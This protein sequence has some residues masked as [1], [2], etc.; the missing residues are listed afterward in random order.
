[1]YR[2]LDSANWPE[3]AAPWTH[4]VLKS[5]L[6]EE[7]FQVSIGS[8]SDSAQIDQHFKPS[9]FHH[10]VDADSS[11]VLAIHDVCQGRNLVIQGPPGTGKSQTITN[12]I[13]EAMGTGKRVLFV[14]EKMAALEVVKRNLDSVGLGNACLELHSHKM[15]KK[16]VADELKRTLELDS[17]QLKSEYDLARLL[18]N[19]DRLNCYCEAV[20]SPI[21]ENG[22][23]PFQAYGE[24]LAVRRR[25]AGLEPPSLDI[26][27]FQQSKSQFEK[28]LERIEELQQ[29]LRRMGVPKNHPFWGSQCKLFVPNDEAEV[30]LSTVKAQ[31]TVTDLRRSSAELAQHLNLPSPVY[32]RSSRKLD[33]CRKP[34]VRCPRFIRYCCAVNRMDGTEQ[35][36]GSRIKRRSTI[37]PAS[38]GIRQY[39]YP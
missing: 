6:D 24:L 22:V 5:I 19:R 23:T 9:D 18:N 29:L 11:Q 7:G 37:E 8:F 4:P 28:G 12:L 20:N 14:A 36:F 33:S 25:L 13:A 34:R 27:Q 39:P 31:E 1:M 35:R 10:V 17:P 21:S 38:Q 30:K 32:S 3:D 26:Y 16:T 2:D 15:N